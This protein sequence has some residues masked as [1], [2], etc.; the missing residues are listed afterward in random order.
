MITFPKDIYI[1]PEPKKKQYEGILL[2]SLQVRK[3]VENL[4]KQVGKVYTDD[5]W[6]TSV[7]RARGK[8]VLPLPEP[9]LFKTDSQKIAESI[10]RIA[11]TNVQNLSNDDIKQHIPKPEEPK[12]KGRGR[13]KAKAES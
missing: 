11:V 5:A 12:K 1:Y 9:K 7:Y 8:I 3:K 10:A 6:I 2:D 4:P 13:G